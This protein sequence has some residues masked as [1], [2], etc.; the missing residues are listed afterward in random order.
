MANA[1]TKQSHS[2]KNSAVERPLIP[3]NYQHPAALAIIYISII[4][5]FHAMV[6]DGKVFQSSDS[7]PVWETF[8]KEVQNKGDSVAISNP[9]LFC[10]MPGYAAFKCPPFRSPSM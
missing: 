4:V 2:A 7:L 3:H 9:Y 6:F 8:L 5:F 1:P 10:G